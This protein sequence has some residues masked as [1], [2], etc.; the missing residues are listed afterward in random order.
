MVGGLLAALRILAA[1]DIDLVNV[2]SEGILAQ[3][4]IIVP[5]T[6]SLYGFVQMLFGIIRKIGVAVSAS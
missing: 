4:A 2:A 6:V 1:T 3:F 5:A